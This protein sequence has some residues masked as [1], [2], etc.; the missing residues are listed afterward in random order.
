M[1]SG[2]LPE[3]FLQGLFVSGLFAGVKIF[4]YLD[5]SLCN[6]VVNFLEQIR[7]DGLLSI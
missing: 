5:K 6:A 1:S 2:S 4:G 3:S 7:L